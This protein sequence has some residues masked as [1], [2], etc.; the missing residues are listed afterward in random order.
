MRKEADFNVTDRINIYFNASGN[1]KKVL[2]DFANDVKG[3]VLA[4][5]II[6]VNE[7]SVGFIKELD[8]NGEKVTLSVE[9]ISK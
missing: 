3:D 8:V 7:V 1:A 2:V 5:N 4:E 6:E 9:K